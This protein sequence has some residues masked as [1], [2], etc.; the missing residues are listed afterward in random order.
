[1][2]LPYDKLND[3]VARVKKIFFT[4]LETSATMM[5]ANDILSLTMR[6]N[7]YNSLI[8]TI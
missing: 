5:T 8:F 6:K 4:L 1:M 2:F 7:R 3:F